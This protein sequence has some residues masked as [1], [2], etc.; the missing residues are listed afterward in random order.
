MID[1]F[2]NVGVVW[3]V[4]GFDDYCG[5]FV[6]FD[7]VV[8]GMLVFFDC[9]YYDGF[10]DIFLFNVVVWNGVFYGGDDDVID[11]GVVL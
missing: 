4:V 2:K 11:V 9:V 8:V 5:V 10:D 7:V 1:W 3:V 6:E